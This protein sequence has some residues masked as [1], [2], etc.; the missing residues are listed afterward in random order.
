MESA[1]GYTSPPSQHDVREAL[2]EITDSFAD[3]FLAANPA[4]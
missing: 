4:N 1:I 3:D 2:E